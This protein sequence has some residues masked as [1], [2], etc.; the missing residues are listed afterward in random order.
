MHDPAAFHH[1]LR[2][3]CGREHSIS[4]V[5]RRIGINRQQFNKYLAGAT[6]PSRRTLLRICD[7]FGVS[8][9]DFLSSAPLPEAR[10]D[11]DADPVRRA[12]Q[13][14]RQKS[15]EGGIAG[16]YGRY[17]KYQYSTIDAGKIVRSL[18]VVGQRGD[19]PGSRTFVRI[20]RVGTGSQGK[21]IFKY[22]GVALLLK[23]RLILIEREILAGSEWTQMILSPSYTRV[24]ERLYG[25]RLGVSASPSRDPFAS[26]VVFERC[27]SNLTTR[28]AM[29]SIGLFD[30]ADPDLPRSIIAA[31]RNGPEDDHIMWGLPD[32]RTRTL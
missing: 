29:R 8:E 21:Q 19:Q 27:P 11:R 31:L 9:A 25:L 13:Q 26:R 3:L 16:Y 22:E 30:D 2:Q 18:V 20:G 12:L 32:R 28:Q 15:A 14:A 17:F 7:F 23:E 6:L 1:K 24:V 4:E 10:I 5:C